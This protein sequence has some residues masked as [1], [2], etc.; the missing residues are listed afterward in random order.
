MKLRRETGNERPVDEEMSDSRR[1]CFK[2]EAVPYRRH[3]WFL[4]ALNE[5]L[6][7]LWVVQVPRVELWPSCRCWTGGASVRERGRLSVETYD[8]VGFALLDLNAANRL[9]S[10]SSMPDMVLGN[11]SKGAKAKAEKPSEV[12]DVLP[13][14]PPNNSPP[15]ALTVDCRTS[16]A[17]PP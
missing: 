13:L 16:P 11:V 5:L 14:A 3:S 12:L 7:R 4:W 9:A 17:A 8:G 10:S 6:L 2:S 15:E 1:R